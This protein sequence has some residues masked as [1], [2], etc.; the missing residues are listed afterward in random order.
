MGGA[1]SSSACKLIPFPTWIAQAAW[2]TGNYG[3]TDAAGVD[4]SNA[5]G[6]ENIFWNSLIGPGP[7][8]PDFVPF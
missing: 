6:Y 2:L 8:D 5:A 4:I 7:S 3:L 1:I